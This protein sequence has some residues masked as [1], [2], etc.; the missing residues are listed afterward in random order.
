MFISRAYVI[1]ASACGGWAF[2][3]AIFGHREWGPLATGAF[4]VIGAGLFAIA[5]FEQVC[6]AE[7]LRKGGGE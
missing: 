2:A 3:T 4:V 1:I 6:A 5:Y 7:R